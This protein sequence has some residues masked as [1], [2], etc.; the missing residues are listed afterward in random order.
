[1]DYLRAAREVALQVQAAEVMRDGHS[2]PAVSEQ[3]ALRR[4]QALKQWR[5]GSLG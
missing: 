5:T 1:V 4:V 3:I 2:G